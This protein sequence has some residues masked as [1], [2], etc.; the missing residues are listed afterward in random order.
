MVINTVVINT[1]LANTIIVT[2][3]AGLTS[4]HIYFLVKSI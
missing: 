2:V 3:D 4:V 1:F